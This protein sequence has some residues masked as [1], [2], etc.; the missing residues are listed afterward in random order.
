VQLYDKWREARAETKDL[1]D[2]MSRQREQMDDAVRDLSRQL[3]L[4]DLIIEAF[5]PPSER[6]KVGDAVAWYRVTA[7]TMVRLSRERVSMRMPM[8]GELK[9]WNS[10]GIS[11]GRH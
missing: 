8:S 5:I 11:C 10:R 7:L 4:R 9:R 6:Q 1:Q 3:R 2:D